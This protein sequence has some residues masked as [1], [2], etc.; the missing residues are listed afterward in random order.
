[1]GGG[2]YLMSKGRQESAEY[3]DIEKEKKILNMVLAQGKVTWAEAATR[4]ERTTRPGRGL[5]A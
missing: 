5:R 3:A 4:A 1:M 2:I